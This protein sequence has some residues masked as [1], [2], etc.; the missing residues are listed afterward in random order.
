MVNKKMKEKDN[1]KVFIILALL[2]LV[3]IPLL[4]AKP[5]EEIEG[6]VM[7]TKFTRVNGLLK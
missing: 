3:L 6:E 7:S 5:T 4:K 2:G 1:G